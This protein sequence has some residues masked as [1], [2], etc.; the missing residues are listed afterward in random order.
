VLPWTAWVI[1]VH[2]VRG[3]WVQTEIGLTAY[4]LVGA[5][6][7]AFVWWGVRTQAKALVNLGMVLFA[8]TVAWFYFSNVMGK[9][10]R[11]LGLIVLGIL[12]LAGGWALEV[13]R[14]KLVRG[15]DG[16]VA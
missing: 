14:R 8:M 9:L 16:G 1:P 2:G 3:T 11:S 7:V 13:T 12:F 5:T 4:A 15:M 10:G 6:A